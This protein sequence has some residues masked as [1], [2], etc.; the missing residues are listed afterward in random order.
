MERSLSGRLLPHAMKPFECTLG[1]GQTEEQGFD[2]ALLKLQPQHL[3]PELS[4]LAR[5]IDSN[6]IQSYC[7]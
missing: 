7:L 1:L 3:L 2:R 6:L 5:E 4:M